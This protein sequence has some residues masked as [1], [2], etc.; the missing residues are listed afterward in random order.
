MFILFIGI[1]LRFMALGLLTF[2]GGSVLLMKRGKMKTARVDWAATV[3]FFLAAY[4][5]LY[6]QLP[7]PSLASVVMLNLVGG[8]IA[9]GI[10]LVLFGGVDLSS[11]IHLTPGAHSGEK[12]DVTP[13][14]K[15]RIKVAGSGFF[16]KIIGWEIALMLVAVVGFSALNIME[17]KQVANIA[18]VTSATSTKEAPM[19]VVSGSRGEVPVV[20]TPQT[21]LT[22]INNSLSNIPNANVYTVDHVR[23]QIMKDTM[24]YIAPLDF[25]GS[26]FRFLR[27]KKVDGYFAV[28]ATSKSAR[29]H[30]VKKAMYY[31]PQAYFGK[32]VRRMMYAH[33]AQ[34]GY[35]LM[36]SAPQLEVDNQ[37]K[38]YYVAT[39]VKRYGVTSRQD[40]R[41]KA[42]VTVSAENGTTHLY[43]DLKDKPD[44][45]DV[46]IDPTTASA[47]VE[48]WARDRNGW[49]NANG[50]GGSRR[51]VMVA[52]AG[53]GTE[54]NDDEITPV[55]F[56]KKIFY[57]QALTSARSSQ[58]SVM[59][60]IFTDAATGKSHYYREVEDAMTPDR[61]Q[62]LA[63]DMMK[64]TGWKP[65]MPMLY[66]IDGKPTWVVSMLDSSGAFRSYVYLLA[67]GNGTQD[68]VATGSSANDTLEKYRALFGA[69]SATGKAKTVKG[70]VLRVS[71]NGDSVNFLLQG[72]TDVVYSTSVKADP[73]VQF[74]QAGDGVTFKARRTGQLG[75][76]VGKLTNT[77]LF[78]K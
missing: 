2:I 26:Y 31:T 59:G 70:T 66:R 63:K 52:V 14:P 22:Q 62:K 11:K 77:N 56:G 10:Q 37:G 27:Y 39:L 23:V 57:L 20:N 7:A 54:G 76:V 21:V 8:L 75:A 24:T 50:Y 42:V 35:V 32:D 13:G 16:A 48:S 67:A 45:L 71:R 29:P 9:A 41:K 69:A 46:A 65:K 53:S 60:Y 68:T 47:Q 4:V 3:L 49:W 58:T 25:D 61:A 44:W 74:L 18:P 78:M 28:D 15:P 33:T 6:M 36:D 34:S 55:K 17:A 30:F 40:F 51:G 64:Q 5:W 19:P 38:P 43:K 12:K 73:T 1:T 72:Q